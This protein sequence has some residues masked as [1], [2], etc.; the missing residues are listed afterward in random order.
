MPAVDVDAG[1]AN[2]LVI[3]FKA[4]GAVELDTPATPTNN[5]IPVLNTTPSFTWH[6]ASSYSNVDEY[7]FEMVNES[8]DTFWG[9]FNTGTGFPNTTPIPRAD[10]ITIDNDFDGTASAPL[11]VRHYYQL[12]I[13][14][15]K[16]DNK[17]PNGLGFKL[18]S[19]T[20]TLD[21]VFIE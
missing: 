11:E 15:S 10:P 14:A 8:G 19:S 1:M 9:G 17:A 20:E 6:Q 7:V 13:Y 4:T 3:D 21:V 5:I 12:R 18:V 16:D 2:P